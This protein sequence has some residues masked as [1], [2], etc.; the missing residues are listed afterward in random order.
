MGSRLWEPF[1]ISQMEL[2]NRIVMPP[3]TT[4]YGSEEGYVTERARNR[5]EVWACGGAA[6]L[7]VEV[8]Y[9]H[10]RG[11][12]FGYQLNI[13]DDKFIPGLSEL[14]QDIQRHG[15]RAAIQLY[16]GGS[17]GKLEMMS[18]RDRWFPPRW[19]LCRA[20]KN[21]RGYCR[22]V[23]GWLEDIEYQ[24]SQKRQAALAL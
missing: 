11:Q 22:G 6:L 16:H 19:G 2:R 8:S 15:A 18:G 5:Y 7:I 4:Q 1:R 21:T 23:S 13:G 17:K 10:P 9:V 3:V 14:A 20:A 12:S 24:E